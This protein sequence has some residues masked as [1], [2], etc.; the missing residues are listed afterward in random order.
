[1]FAFVS[2]AFAMHKRERDALRRRQADK[3]FFSKILSYVYRVSSTTGKRTRPELQVKAVQMKA[4]QKSKAKR[5]KRLRKRMGDGDG[6]LK[7]N[8]ILSNLVIKLEDCVGQDT[9]WWLAHIGKLR[10]LR[11][12]RS[13]PL[14]GD[15]RRKPV[16]LLLSMAVDDAVQET[17]NE[18]TILHILVRLELQ[19]TLEFL[20]A[21]TE[22]QNLP[23]IN[24]LDNENKPPLFYAVTQG[25][26]DLSALLLRNGAN[27]RFTDENDQTFLHHAAR[28]NNL[29]LIRLILSN[30]F[31]D[32]NARDNQGKTALHYLVENNNFDAARILILEFKANANIA[33]NND[34]TV[35]GRLA[36]SAE[37]QAFL[38]ELLHSTGDQQRGGLN[39]LVFWKR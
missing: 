20:F 32:V 35:I 22:R 7:L 12:I 27:I 16:S 33:G 6:N 9:I 15:P 37:G 10:R 24:A 29:N 31:V 26:V 13:L 5:T 14:I 11:G 30:G 1:M 23:D 17:E 28:L 2:P 18:A 19:E 34:V 3:P 39:F 25:N 38:N 8:K 36:E 4:V 21:N